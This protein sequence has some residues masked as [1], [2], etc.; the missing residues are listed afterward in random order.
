MADSGLYESRRRGEA[1]TAR[2]KLP[3]VIDANDLAIGAAF[4]P[5]GRLLLFARDTRERCPANSSFGTSTAGNRG[6]PPV[7]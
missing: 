5:S 4:S 3:P 2:R 7:Q 6:C 1:W